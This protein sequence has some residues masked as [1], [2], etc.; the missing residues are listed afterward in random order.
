[1]G[2]DNLARKK[3][4]VEE[5]LE[6]E[7]S[8]AEKHEYYQG[9]IFSMAGAK[10]NHN[11]IVSNL[12]AA[13]H[14][15]FKGSS[16]LVYP[17]DMRVVTDKYHHYTYPDLSLVCEKSVFLDDSENTLVNPKV[18]IEVLSD[19]T[20]KYDRGKKFQLYRNIVSLQEYMLVSSEYKQ[21]EIFSKINDNQWIL[22]DPTSGGELELVS[23]NCRLSLDD[24][25][26]KVKI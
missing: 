7:N 23:V 17:S 6:M 21:V 10:K 14:S 24:I 1:M 11:L 15:Q 25:Y 5:Y 8:S 9:E 12:I 16:C 4:T 18:I 22:S 2:M 20:E 26:E 13:F 19:S 3:L